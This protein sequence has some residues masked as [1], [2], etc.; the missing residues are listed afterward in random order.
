MGFAA[1][2]FG[3]AAF[4]GC[5]GYMCLC[6][7]HPLFFIAGLGF[8]WAAASEAFTGILYVVA[9]LKMVNPGWM[10]KDRAGSIKLLPRLLSWPLLFFEYSAWR[11]Y[12]KRGREPLFE[13]VADGLYLGARVT[14]DDVPGL[15][16]E[17]IKAVLDMIAEFPAPVELREDPGMAY[18]CLPV[19][20]GT[21]PAYA[22]MAEGV[23][24]I[25]RCVKNGA[26]VLAHCTFGHGRS[27]VM[28]AAALVRLGLCRDIDEALSRLS[29]LRRRI[30]LS[31][32]Q[33]KVLAGFISAPGA[34]L[35]AATKPGSGKGPVPGDAP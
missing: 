27:A 1:A 17:G 26:P 16:D 18:L 5:A 4:F 25:K 29:G 34:D 30:W 14:G 21:A 10:F 32:S 33:Q 12:R 15:K 6:Q 9:S 8:L 13:R 24:F 35:A 28:A 23:E 19:L 22:D 3:L 20:D 7:G 2:F 31:R 11:R